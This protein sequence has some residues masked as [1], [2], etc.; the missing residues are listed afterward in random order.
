DSRRRLQ[1]AFGASARVFRPLSLVP[2]R[3]EEHERWL[4]PPLG[5]CRRDELIEDDLRPVDEVAVLRF[6]EHEVRWFLDVVAELEADGAVLTQRAVMD[7]ERRVR[8]GERL[9]RDEAIAVH[10]IV[11]DG[12]AAAERAALDIFTGEPDRGAVGEN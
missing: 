11:E 1:N 10:R 5:P 8:M 4:Q 6:P 2:V 7:F 9:Q 12:M 3:K